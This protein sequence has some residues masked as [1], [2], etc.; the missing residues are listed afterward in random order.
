[1]VFPV[2]RAFQVLVE[3]VVFPV[4]RAFQVLVGF[5]VL[6]ASLDFPDQVYRVGRVFQDLVVSLDLVGIQELVIMA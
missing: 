6:V 2:G 1:M 5:Q 3:L 4:G